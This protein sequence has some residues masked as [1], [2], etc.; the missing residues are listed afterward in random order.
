MPQ[1]AADVWVVWSGCTQPQCGGHNDY[2]PSAQHFHNFS[3]Q[4]TEFFGDGG[5]ANELGT[6]RVNDTVTFSNISIL[7]TTIGAAFSL[8][9]GGEG[10]DGNFGM[11]KCAYCSCKSCVSCGTPVFG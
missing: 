2:V 4:D 7:S 5:P 8:P 11:A 1:L 3:I 9:S 10:L 6:W